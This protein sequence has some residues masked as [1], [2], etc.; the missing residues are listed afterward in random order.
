MFSLLNAFTGEGCEFGV[1]PHVA[2]GKVVSTLGN[3]RS[4]KDIPGSWAVDSKGD[5]YQ[6]G[7]K[8]RSKAME[9]V[10]LASSSPEQQ[11]YSYPIFLPTLALPPATCPMDGAIWFRG[12]GW[13]C[14]R[15]Q[16]AQADHISEFHVSWRA[17]HDR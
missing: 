1:C 4:L 8:V 11:L 12:Y 9:E 2:P 5:I 3:Y 6:N 10:I 17:T 15:L 7:Q 14:S 16:G 13:F